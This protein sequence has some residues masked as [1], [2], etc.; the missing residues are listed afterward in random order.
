MCGRFETDSSLAPQISSALQIPFQLEANPNVSPSQ[1]VATVTIV[2][3]SLIQLNANWG[4]KPS[5]AKRLLINAQVE[6]VSQKPTFR[7]SYQQ[8]RCLIP[9]RSWFEWRK[10]GSRKVKYRFSDGDENPLFMAGIFFGTENNSMVSLTTQADQQTQPYHQRMPY[11][12][13]MA[14]GVGEWLDKG[15]IQHAS[16]IRLAIK[17]SQDY[18]IQVAE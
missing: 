15:E 3:G 16:T 6:G 9:I 17:N 10:E 5:W 8:R 11:L 12:F 7:D 13:T 14:Q 18:I 4:I 2:D 1:E